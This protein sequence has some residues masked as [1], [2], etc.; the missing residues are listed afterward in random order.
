MHPDKKY[1]IIKTGGKQYPVR[2]GDII[3]IELVECDS[4]SNVE[5][6]DVLFVSDGSKIE[7]ASSSVAE[8][9]VSGKVLGMVPGE[10]VTSL[11]YK[12]S[13]TT[14]RKWGHRQKYSRVEITA[15]EKKQNSK[16]V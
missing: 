4:D 5:F 10:K 11:K 9:S 2:V 13:H 8:F 3:D 1:A 7:V 15:I 16:D 14:C 6:G 12:P